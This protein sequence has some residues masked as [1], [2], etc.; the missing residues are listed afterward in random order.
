[1]ISAKTRILSCGE[2]WRTPQPI[3]SERSA[4]LSGGPTGRVQVPFLPADDPFR[5]IF[6]DASDG[7]IVALAPIEANTL[8]D[9]AQVSR[10][11]EG[12]ATHE[13]ARVPKN[14]TRIGGGP[15]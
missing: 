4:C 12:L 15:T 3:N 9:I 8:A 10:T 1:M 7:T 11:F 2:N 14:G 5:P 6:S 13:N